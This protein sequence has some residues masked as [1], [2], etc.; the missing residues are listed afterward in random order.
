MKG[1][2]WEKL[3][4]YFL[5]SIGFY[6]PVPFTSRVIFPA[7]SASLGLPTGLMVKNPPVNAGDTRDTGLIP[8]S[9]RPPGVGNG[10]PL[11]YSCLGNLVDRGAWQATVHGATESDTTEHTVQ[12]LKKKVECLL[13]N[14]QILFTWKCDFIPHHGDCESIFNE[15]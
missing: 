12:T 11:Q 15:G 8:G 6:N 2:K 9:G 4:R 3:S 10:S 1:E 5:T 7:S 14:S 13:R